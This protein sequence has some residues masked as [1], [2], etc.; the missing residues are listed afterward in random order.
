M[1]TRK[2]LARNGVGWSRRGSQHKHRPVFLYP[3]CISLL[4]QTH[5][6]VHRTQREREREMDYSMQGSKDSYSPQGK[7]VPLPRSL[8]ARLNSIVC[9]CELLL[10][11]LC[12]RLPAR[13]PSIHTFFSPCPPTNFTRREIRQELLMVQSAGF[14]SFRFP[15]SH[16]AISPSYCAPLWM[17]D[18]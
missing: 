18:I 7:I 12:T 11:V 16:H 14:Q 9:S 6:G 10:L 5:R 17:L 4:P 13:I 2:I 15:G 8:R 1:P 3:S